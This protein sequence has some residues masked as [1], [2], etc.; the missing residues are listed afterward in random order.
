MGLGRIR[1][2]AQH[3]VRSDAH[4][5]L[6]GW[7]ALSISAFALVLRYGQNIPAWEEWYYLPVFF[8]DS[9]RVPWLFERLHEHRYILG[10]A[11]FLV[12]FD[13]SGGDFRAGMFLSAG[14]LSAAGWVLAR[15][16]AEARGRAD[17]ADLLLPA[18]MLNLAGYENL[19]LGYQVQFTLN[20]LLAAVFLRL[21]VNFEPGKP[22]GT[23]TKAGALTVPLALGGWVGL[24]FVPPLTIWVG[25]LVWCGKA[26]VPAR[27]LLAALVLPAVSCAVF[28]VLYIEVSVHPTPGRVPN[29]PATIARVAGEFLATMFGGLSLVWLAAA[30]VCAVA[31][32]AAS[33]GYLGWHVAFRK[34]RLAGAGLVVLAAVAL[35]AFATARWRTDG[36]AYRNVPLSGLVL[37][38]TCLTAAKAG[39]PA[40][41]SS[42]L[43]VL[44]FAVALTIAGRYEGVAAGQAMRY[45]HRAFS[46]SAKSGIPSDYLAD[47]HLLFPYPGMRAAVQVLRDHVHPSVA[48]A[49]DPRPVVA[50]TL[51]VL[52]PTY[53]PIPGDPFSAVVA[54]HPP[55]WRFDLASPGPVA[56]LRVRFRFPR[57]SVRVPIHVIATG[58]GPGGPVTAA[59]CSAWLTPGEWTLDFWLDRPASTLWLR[60]LSA[61]NAFEV[62]D[63][64]LLRP[65]PGF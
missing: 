55:V 64:Q 13:L 49:T 10:R 65:A 33:A 6:V 19:L 2:V 29:D 4:I 59:A 5:V 12:G 57:A 63:V 61:E 43:V 52:P 3:F 20:V 9:P 17:G 28:A 47:R 34:S 39:W 62:L 7:A 46:Q 32:F 26:G 14:L 30:G 50:T 25:W 27:R 54:G 56:A 42:R 45:D 18:L 37:A 36:F 24:A 11:V 21:A 40:A 53:D 58:P 48:G 44:G 22:L 8:G 31:A 38:A 51:P 41:R 23:A 1:V 60:P 35:M 15:A 16:A